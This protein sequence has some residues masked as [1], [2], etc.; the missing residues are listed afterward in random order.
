MSISTSIHHLTTAAGCILLLVAASFASCSMMSEDRDDCPTGLYVTFKYDYN[1]QRADMFRDHV[2]A[3]TL[4]V[5]NER[6]ELVCT[7]SE[8][9]R[10][11]SSPLRDAAYRMHITGLQPGRYR[12]IALAGQRPYDEMLNDHTRARF[13]RHEPTPGESMQTLDVT[14]D[15][16]PLDLTG[17]LFEVKNLSA[18][19]DTLWHAMSR[20]EIE[21]KATGSK[22]VYDTLSLVRDTKKINITLREL[23]EPQRMDIDD[24]ELT[25]TD[26]NAHLLWDNSL[27]EAH[28]VVY[29]PH[30]T[31]N[32]DDLPAI[33]GED[34]PGRMGHADFM[35]S[36]ILKHA[37]AA[38]DAVLR[39]VH[40]STGKQ[41]AAV[42]LADYLSR[43]RVA[44]E[45][46]IY[47]VQEFLDRGYDYRLT[48]F[49]RGDRFEYVSIEISTLSW[50]VHVQNENLD[51]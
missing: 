43:L 50:S 14:L 1:L 3:V 28:T 51:R 40:K 9:N 47:S 12:L 29:T 24:Y 25:I 48:F 7:Q 42:N 46:Y 22:P 23:D 31:W 41:V 5:F 2:E 10:P 4:Y 20:H 36:R 38:D 18:P 44:E 16:Q 21:V 6:G 13:V 11:A 45:R 26:H 49:L 34:T 17:N 27:D 33:A 37:S 32:T 8:A 35:T 15:H 39:I 30:A 19:L